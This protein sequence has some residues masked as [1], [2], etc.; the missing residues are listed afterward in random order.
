[1]RVAV[2]IPAFQAGASVGDVVRAARQQMPDVLVLD[3]GSTDGTAAKAREAG[4]EVISFP[5]NRGKGTALG[6]AFRVLFA[7]GF[8]AVVT[9]DADGQHLPGE[10]PKLLALAS[11][12]D[13]I[14]GTREHL[15]ADMTNLR[16][17][18]NRLSSR[19]ISFAAGQPFSDV[20]TGFRLYTRPLI[21]RIGLPT[22]RF[23]AESAMVVRA[24]RCGLRVMTTPVKLGFANG[25]STSHYRPFIDSVRIAV[26]VIGARLRGS[27]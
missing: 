9:V 25:L 1:M 15:F 12:A 16:R 10:I 7:R 27:R 23:E 18:S 22:G 19:A 11:Q 24:A 17:R 14:L 2:A 6:E 8:D 13:L 5:V 26:A 20:Q 4:A 21:E 3:D